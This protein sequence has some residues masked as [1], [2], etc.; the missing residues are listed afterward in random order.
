M[1]EC[2]I[3]LRHVSKIEHNLLWRE[4]YTRVCRFYDKESIIIIDDNS[5]YSILNENN[6]DL[7]SI[8]IIRSEFKGRAELLPYYYFHLHK[9]AEKA[10]FIHDSVFLNAKIESRNVERFAFLWNFEHTWDDDRLVVP[11]IAELKERETL[12]KN[13]FNKE[14]WKGCYGVMS[15]ITWDFLNE[16]N[17]RYA[18]LETLL[19]L[20]I[21]REYR[22]G[23][24]RIFA[25]CC[26]SMYEQGCIPI[27]SNIHKWIRYQTRGN[28]EWGYHYSDY[29]EDKEYTNAL[30]AIKILSS[31]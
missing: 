1:K 25:L 20:I 14:K 30:R 21:N 8:R 17:S 4:C 26:F 24:E 12:L 9:F 15:V 5:D 29:E 28:R 19:K 18:F 16:M 13:Y 10:I 27:F 31:R 6:I 23:L 3:I 2:I 22:M 11:C 7:S